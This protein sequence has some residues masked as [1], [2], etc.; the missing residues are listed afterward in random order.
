MNCVGPCSI[1]HY[2]KSLG[3]VY[4]QKTDYNNKNAGVLDVFGYTFTR[5]AISKTPIK[6]NPFIV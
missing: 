1:W 3:K 4:I 6:K 2:R 5:R